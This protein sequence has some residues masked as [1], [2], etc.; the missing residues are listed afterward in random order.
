MPDRVWVRTP[1]GRRSTVVV[2]P[3]VPGE[4]APTVGPGMLARR[5][6]VPLPQYGEVSWRFEHLGA[7]LGVQSRPGTHDPVG[8]LWNLWGT[9]SFETLPF[10][11]PDEIINMRNVFR[12]LSEPL[13]EPLRYLYSDRALEGQGLPLGAVP[14]VSGYNAVLTLSR[15]PQAGAN[16]PDKPR[17][18]RNYAL[19]HNAPWMG[20]LRSAEDRL[21][22]WDALRPTFETADDVERGALRRW[23]DRRD[24]IERMQQET[25]EPF[26]ATLA[27]ADMTLRATG[28]S[29]GLYVPRF[30]AGDQFFNWD[31]ERPDLYECARILPN[32]VR[33]IAPPYL[34]AGRR[35]TT[36]VTARLVPRRHEILFSWTSVYLVGFLFAPPVMIAENNVGAYADILPLDWSLPDGLEDARNDQIMAN[37][38]KTSRRYQVAKAQDYGSQIFSPYLVKILVS[39]D[40]GQW[41]VRRGE[42]AVGDLCVAL[43]VDRGGYDPSLPEARRRGRRDR[44]EFTRLTDDLGG[45]KFGQGRLLVGGEVNPYNEEGTPLWAVSMP[46]GG[47]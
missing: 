32:G 41:A 4:L 11:L 40:D 43:D 13:A 16:D 9:R 19:Q 14:I 36:R 3:L 27:G 39:R 23:Q 25:F 20:R 33:Q 10:P 30:V 38:I 2:R 44:Y 6:S 1:A 24:E 46:Y 42:Q 37:W 15:V 5:P 45:E 8:D 22:D 26:S 31:A 28:L 21:A 47:L 17:V 12:A 29:P 7:Y 18:V 35:Q 34:T